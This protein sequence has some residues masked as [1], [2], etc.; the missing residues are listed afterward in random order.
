MSL[1][2]KEFIDY[3]TN[4]NGANQ[5]KLAGL[6]MIFISLFFFFNSEDKSK[7]WYVSIIGII[8]GSLW[9]LFALFL[10]M[11]MII[12][13]GFRG[14]ITYEL[15]MLKDTMIITSTKFAIQ[16]FLLLGL[17]F[18]FYSEDNENKKGSEKIKTLAKIILGLTIL[19]FLSFIIMIIKRV[20]NS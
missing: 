6:L 20:K 8:A 14:Y 2:I 11:K 10:G 7:L 16:I 13:K 9:L 19:Y 17:F 1:K 18:L 12:Q 4:L 5:N 3:M 15:C